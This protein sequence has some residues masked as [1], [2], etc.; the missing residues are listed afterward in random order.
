M[1]RRYVRVRSM[2]S[3]LFF[4]AEVMSAGILSADRVGCSTGHEKK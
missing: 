3:E 1:E 2:E 4:S